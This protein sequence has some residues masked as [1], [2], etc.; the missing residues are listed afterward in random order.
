MN[1][2]ILQWL[3]V[4]WVQIFSASTAGW[5]QISIEHFH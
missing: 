1:K 2:R 5:I 3:W 4:P